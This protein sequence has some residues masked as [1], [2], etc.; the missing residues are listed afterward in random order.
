MFNLLTAGGV[1]L[2]LLVLAVFAFLR[3]FQAA[4]PK[5]QLINYGTALILIGMVL[6]LMHLTR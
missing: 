2:I 5:E 6:V 1:A 3:A 4:E